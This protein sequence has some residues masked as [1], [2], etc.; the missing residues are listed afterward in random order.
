MASVWP[1]CCNLKRIYG[2]VSRESSHVKSVSH[3]AVLARQDMEMIDKLSEKYDEA[4]ESPEH[5]SQN[6]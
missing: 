3:T 2:Q 6:R 4:G 5:R 1:K